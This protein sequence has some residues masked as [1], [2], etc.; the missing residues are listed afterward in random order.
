MQYIKE[1]RQEK[2][3]TQEQLAAMIGVTQGAV[4]QWENGLSHPSFTKIPRLAD[5]LGITIDELMRKAG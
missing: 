5:A 4:A 1:A 2:G 3:L